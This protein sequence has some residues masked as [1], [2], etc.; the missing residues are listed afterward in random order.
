MPCLDDNRVA[1][2]LLGQL[3]EAEAAETEA[4]LVGC[5][6]CRALVLAAADVSS[7]GTPSSEPAA[8]AASG[9]SAVGAARA[10]ATVPR[11]AAAGTT[12]GRY[13]VLR[14]VGAG[15]FGVVYAAY[16]P[17]LD[18]KVAL[19]VLSAGWSPEGVTALPPERIAQE[20]RAMARLANP[21]VVGVY[22]VELSGDRVVIAMEFIDGPNARA[23]LA[24]ASPGAR[25]ILD[26][27]IKAGR[28]L[29]AAHSAEVVH[30]DFKAENVLV[31]QDGRVAVG[32]FGLAH[33]HTKDG[34]IEGGA[35]AAGRT[36]AGTLAFMAPEA[37]EGVASALA[38]Q[39]SFAA[40]LFLALYG[41]HPFEGTSGSEIARAVRAGQRR[42]VPLP[43][44]R[45][46]VPKWVRRALEKSLARDP[47]A[48]FPSMAALLDALSPERRGLWTRVLV[49]GLALVAVL[50]GVLVRAQERSRWCTGGDERVHEVWPAARR[51][52]LARAFAASGAPHAEETWSATERAFDAYFRG[53][54]SA[55]KDACEATR[56]RREQSD[57]VLDARMACLA[58]RH[59]GARAL[60][61]ELERGEPGVVE[62]AP[63]AVTGLAD[64]EACANVRE[65]LAAPPPPGRDR[66][67]VEG[68]RAAL[69]EGRALRDTG[70]IARARERVDSVL[71]EARAIGYE[72]LVADALV[73]R[74]DLLMRG[75]DRKDAEEV[76]DEAVRAAAR[77]RND[78]AEAQAAIALVD[79]TGVLERDATRGLAHR[80]FARASL[81]RLGT[82]RAL[83]A[84]LASVT[85]LMLAGAGD[86]PAAL[87]AAQDS[88]HLA[89]EAYGAASPQVGR[90]HARVAE[91]DD[92]LGLLDDAKDH[93]ERA[94]S[95]LGPSL[96]EHHATLALPWTL[97]GDVAVRRGAFADAQM[98]V[99][100]AA[101]ARGKGAGDADSAA[102]LPTAR[103][104]A[105][106]LAGHDRTK[107]ALAVL[108]RAEAT[109]TAAFGRESAWAVLLE[110][111]TADVARRA[112]DAATARSHAEHA[113]AVAV[114]VG[115]AQHPDTAL[116]EEALGR[117]LHAV[118]EEAPAAAA[119]DR[120]IAAR[121]VAFGATSPTLVPALVGAARVAEARGDREAARRAVDRALSLPAAGS[122][123]YEEARTL[124]SEF[125]VR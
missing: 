31:G 125:G 110:V 102:L 48:R 24:E 32:D 19:K 33:T 13:I 11:I 121:E 85:G 47:A 84:R 4:H 3:S 29:A 8:L 23:W 60:L 6:G 61:R 76:L 64:V 68:A 21:Y 46:R 5:E 44:G 124:R 40:S 77:G 74:G 81:A 27:F 50:S 66:A 22:D 42:H 15:G 106:A 78:R 18:R 89:A 26:V 71:D 41:E 103:V 51:A 12:L 35:S 115:G 54:A 118:G 69:A 70:Q 57:E 72:P 14:P 1:A 86:F 122:A 53:W 10:V 16:D 98:F 107:E 95:I 2:Y 97:L 49:A 105:L 9:A 67:R 114:A 119:F 111:A 65:L 36:V 43:R 104:Y 58:E 34:A 80:T 39:W 96:G 25:E 62:G 75:S 56:V 94:L 108:A 28:G 116:A 52:G 37:H 93:A 20:G 112:G 88:I 79:L 30:R 73:F 82:D 7:A 90:E 38:D 109:A 101:A 59:A 100:R 83:E 113:R 55:Y 91:L 99:E 120:A 63:L 45:A 87:R 117:A 92:E 123:A 17:K